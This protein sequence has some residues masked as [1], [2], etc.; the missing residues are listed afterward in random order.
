MSD[1]AWPE[2]S[3]KC[4]A[5][6][7][8]WANA[9]QG[10]QFIYA[11]YR[12]GTGSVGSDTRSTPGVY[13]HA[14]A[15]YGGNLTNTVDPD[16][17]YAVDPFTIHAALTAGQQWAEPTSGVT[18][19][20]MAMGA[21]ATV[22]LTFAAPGGAAPKCI[23][24]TAPPS[25]PMCGAIG[26]GGVG[27][28][29]AGGAG[30]RMDGGATAG[31]GGMGVGGKAGAGGQGG[32]AGNGVAGGGSGGGAAGA[33]Q[34]GGAGHAGAGVGGTGVGTLTGTTTTGA[35]PSGQDSGCGC[36]AA[37]A[38]SPLRPAWFLAVFAV[39]LGRRRPR[40]RVFT[41]GRSLQRT[42]NSRLSS[43]SDA[44]ATQEAGCPRT[45]IGSQQQHAPVTERS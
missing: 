6:W 42:E 24:G 39:F 35:G 29:G 13:L 32:A 16:N 17:R 22:E 21:T 11:E 31:A 36:R 12:R 3:Q 20:V 25:A 4:S 45:E 14:S 27:A 8:V 38:S 18:F 2:L 43:A 40:H 41:I 33:A 23:D 28:G 44:F 10:P 19:R 1:A 9:N 7:C 37:G 26:D 30:G 15:V 34:G 5:F